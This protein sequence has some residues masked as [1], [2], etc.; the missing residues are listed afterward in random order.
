MIPLVFWTL[1]IWFLF[2]LMN[3]AAMFDRLR[4]AVMPALPRW[5]AYSVSCAF[6]TAFWVLAAF[7]LFTGWTPLLLVCPPTTLMWDLAYRRLKGT[8][9]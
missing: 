7:S 4:A 3:H 2:Y 9:E 5:I 6:C 1:A 8:N